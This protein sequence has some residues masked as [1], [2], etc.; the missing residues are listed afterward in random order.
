MQIGNN[1]EEYDYNKRYRNLEI[2]SKST[3]KSEKF[4]PVFLKN[5]K[6]ETT[7][8]NKALYNTIFCI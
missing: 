6:E 7:F 8:E 4:F 5:G 3:I 1:I 2:E